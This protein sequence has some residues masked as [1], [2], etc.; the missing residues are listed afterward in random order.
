[1]AASPSS[2]VDISTN[3]KP[4]ERPV[5]LSSTM[6]ADSTVPACAKSCCNSSP[7]VWNER[8]PTYSFIDIFRL[9][10]PC[11][12]ERSCESEWLRSNGRSE[13][14]C[15]NALNERLPKLKSACSR[16]IQDARTQCLARGAHHR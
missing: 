15:S 10:S 6:L 13:G 14:P 11:G 5:S 9:P 7:E 16:T 8:F 3:P 4:R 12:N 2:L 1:M